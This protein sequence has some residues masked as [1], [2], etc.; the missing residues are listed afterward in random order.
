[1]RIPGKRLRPISLPHSTPDA[2]NPG[3]SEFTMKRDDPIAIIDHHLLS[4]P[5]GPL[6][7]ILW[8]VRKVP[9]YVESRLTPEIYSRMDEF[10]NE[11]L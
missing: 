3:S 4:L 11:E 7:D 9:T 1:M 8:A 2:E 5:S 6:D 10:F